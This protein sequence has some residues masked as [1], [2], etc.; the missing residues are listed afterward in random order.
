MSTDMQVAIVGVIGTVCGT[1]LGWLLNNLSQ[2]GKLSCYIQ[3]WTEKMCGSFYGCQTQ[4]EMLNEAESYNYSVSLE[5]YNSS[6]TSKIMRQIE[7]VFCS[8]K[9]VLKIDVPQDDMTRRSS[10]PLVYFDDIGP[11]NISPKTVG[12]IEMHGGW[13]KKDEPFDP[14]LNATEIY[15]RYHDENNKEVKILL[16]KNL[17]RT[18]FGLSDFT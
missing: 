7:I 5:V 18:R 13:W 4:A 9:T 16:K 12:R 1:V 8:G 6:S 14:A 17:T 11:K 10:G 3:T 15:L 2:S